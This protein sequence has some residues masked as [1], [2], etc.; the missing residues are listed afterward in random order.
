MDSGLVQYICFMQGFFFF[1]EKEVPELSKKEIKEKY[2]GFFGTVA[3]DCFPKEALELYSTMSPLKKTLLCYLLNATGARDAELTAQ[4]IKDLAK[5][6]Y[7]IKQTADFECVP[8]GRACPKVKPFS[9]N[10][11]VNGKSFLSSHFYIHRK[12]H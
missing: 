4:R 6:E 3:L 10:T 11:H 8:E 2:M 9:A 5:S 7:Q 1:F 12:S